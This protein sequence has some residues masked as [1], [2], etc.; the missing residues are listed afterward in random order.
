MDLTGKKVVVAGNFLTLESTRDATQIVEQLGGQ[1]MGSV[2][3]KTDFILLGAEGGAKQKKAESMGTPV[4]T[5][6]DLL[7][8]M[9]KF[10]KAVIE[11]GAALPIDTQL[12]SAFDY[13]AIHLK[14]LYQVDGRV[15]HT[16]PDTE[17]QPEALACSTVAAFNAALKT[18][19][20]NIE[21][22]SLGT[23]QD[24]DLKADKY[25]GLLLQH[26]D[27]FPQLRFLAFQAKHGSIDL[28]EMLAAFP[29]LEGFYSSLAKLTTS[30]PIRHH[31]LT[32]LRF[33]GDPSSLS[34]LF[35]NCSMPRLEKLTV[36]QL[37]P[38]LHTIL[39]QLPA[40]RHFGY[41]KIKR[42]GLADAT[43]LL[44]TLP[45]PDTLQSIRVV[46]LGHEGLTQLGNCKW[47]QQLKHI[48][49]VRCAISADNNYI[50]A[51]AAPRLEKLQIANGDIYDILLQLEHSDLPH[52][53]ALGF[54]NCHL[55]ATTG[56][57]VR[58]LALQLGARFVDVGHN[59]LTSQKQIDLFASMPCPADTRN[60]Y[61][62][63]Y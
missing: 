18:D 41:S 39:K 58:L 6:I 38:S 25:T 1:V 13:D 50:N 5:E 23:Y 30:A 3:R 11:T 35:I 20:S 45:F 49:L 52:N 46:G 7:C 12:D 4:L 36:N 26:A 48:T 63:F 40:L 15:I 27:K 43:E 56:H 28:S 54:T 32:E 53:I 24:G 60:Q 14:C 62:G 22:L 61:S 55:N 21:V 47:W 51:N 9:G 33:H 59:C 57:A 16:P 42:G 37:E 31:V 17:N 10:D 44:S 34:D 8:S 19:L 29:N 2:S